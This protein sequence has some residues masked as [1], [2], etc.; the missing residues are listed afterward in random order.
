MTMAYLLESHPA[1]A[2]IAGYLIAFLISFAIMRLFLDR[3][4][5]RR[6]P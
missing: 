4:L 1:F 3:R 2:G 6:R 5:W